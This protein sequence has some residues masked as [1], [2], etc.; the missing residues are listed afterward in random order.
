MV[1]VGWMVGW[2]LGA[3]LLAAKTESHSVYPVEPAHNEPSHLVLQYVQRYLFWSA[4][5]EK[6]KQTK[7][8][9]IQSKFI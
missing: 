1:H 9:I 4:G 7:Q 2:R 3:F 5:F 6:F 8:K